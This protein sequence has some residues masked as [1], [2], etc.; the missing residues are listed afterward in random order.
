MYIFKKGKFKYL[1]IRLQLL[2]YLAL[3]FSLSIL[4]FH[5]IFIEICKKARHIVYTYLIL[6][7]GLGAL[8]R[9]Y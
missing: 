3:L 9:F 6:K 8:C 7:F 2:I 1:L 4:H 5:S